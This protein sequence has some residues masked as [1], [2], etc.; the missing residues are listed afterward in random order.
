MGEVRVK[1]F[2]FRD[3][4]LPLPSA[5]VPP[6]LKLLQGWK[7]KLVLKGSVIAAYT[8]IQLFNYLLSKLLQMY[9]T[10]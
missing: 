10:V 5:N 2:H 3:T 4:P 6:C 7:K 8:S 1:V 9:I